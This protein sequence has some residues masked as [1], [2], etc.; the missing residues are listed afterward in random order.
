VIRRFLLLLIFGLVL[1]GAMA[2]NRAIF[3]TRQPL[4]SAINGQIAL[5]AAE[6]LWLPKEVSASSSADVEVGSK[7]AFF[8]ETQTGRVL[9][10]K[11]IHQQLRI[12]SLTKIMSV[13][14]TM[15]HKKFEDKMVVSQ[16]ASDMEPDKMLLKP[17]ET[18]SA[19]ELLDGIFT[20]SANDAAEVLA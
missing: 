20:V 17:N 3:D 1:V 18:L 16:Q 10:Q 13:I 8:V 12:A 19:E 11:N 14:V 2:F 4:I 15:E 7:A 5:K 6:N 9:Y